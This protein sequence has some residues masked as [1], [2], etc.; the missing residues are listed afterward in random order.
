MLSGLLFRYLTSARSRVWATSAEDSGWQ[1]KT[2]ESLAFSI[3]IPD[4]VRRWPARRVSV[5]QL[6][7]RSWLILSILLIS[8][9]AEAQRSVSATDSDNTG[10]DPYKPPRNQV[11][12]MY[13]YKTIPGSPRKVTTD[14]LNL[15]VDHR[16][17]LTPLWNLALRA[18]LPLVTKNPITVGNPA[19]GYMHGLGDIYIQ[20][21]VLHD[22]N[23]RTL[24]GFG[25]RLITPTGGDLGS[26]NWMIMPIVGMRYALP[27]IS[28]SSYFEPRVRYV[29][30]FAGDSTKN[31]TSNLQF[32]PTLNVGFPDHWF[33]ILYPSEDIRWNFGDAITGQTGRLFL[34]FAARIGRK[35]TKD[36]ALSSEIG[37]PIVEYYPVYHF[38]IQL[39][40]NVSY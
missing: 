22:S 17:N 33:V 5:T 38:K 8:V 11:Q 23:A 18:N 30:S 6:L 31:T 21:V 26:G 9:S 2:R 24:V 40:L 36:I 37:V 15:R 14:T 4:A 19:G 1:M 34:P 28:S 35:L 16:S 7:T 32:A 25:T 20:G 3:A 27:E 29:V 10:N 12:V 13:Q 39:R